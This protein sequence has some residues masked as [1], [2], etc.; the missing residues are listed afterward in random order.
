MRF[1]K[2]INIRTPMQ[3]VVSGTQSLQIAMPYGSSTRRSVRGL[4][5][6][7]LGLPQTDWHAKHCVFLV[8]T[9]IV[10]QNS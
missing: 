6:N 8:R 5:T 1:I 10:L 4:S 3:R 2:S 7:S 9:G